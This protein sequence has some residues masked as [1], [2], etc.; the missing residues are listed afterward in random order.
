MEVGTMKCPNCGSVRVG[1]VLTD[2]TD[3]EDRIRR[4]RC[5]ICEH[6]WYTFQPAEISVPDYAITWPSSRQHPRPRVRYTPE[7]S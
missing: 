7:A 2:L 3:T 4:R 6:R 5:L 1:V